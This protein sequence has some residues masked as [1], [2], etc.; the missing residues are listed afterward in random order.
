[1]KFASVIRV[2]AVGTALKSL[3][4]EWALPGLKLSEGQ[5]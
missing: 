2:V 4:S 3:S 1:M 5:R